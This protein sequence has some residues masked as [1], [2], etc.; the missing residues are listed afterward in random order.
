MH[1]IPALQL[2][3]H[4]SLC[5]P[6][7]SSQGFPNSKLL[8]NINTNFYRGQ[9]GTGNSNGIPGKNELCLGMNLFSHFCHLVFI[10]RVNKIDKTYLMQKLKHRYLTAMMGYITFFGYI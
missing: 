7:Y 2:I 9:T 8:F 10:F 6:D 5:V 3:L 4:V 1:K